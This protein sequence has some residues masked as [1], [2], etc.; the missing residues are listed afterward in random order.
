MAL[1]TKQQLIDRFESRIGKGGYYELSEKKAE[2]FIY[3][4]NREQQRPSA[5]FMT[6]D[7]FLSHSSSDAREVGGLK[8]KL[9]DL[10]YSVYV[11]WIEDPQLNRTKVTKANAETLRSRMK[12][13]KS[14][15]YAFSENARTSTWMPWELGFFDGI[16]GTVAVLP[17]V[18]GSPR[19]FK[20]NEYIELYPYIDITGSTL[21]VHESE[22]KYKKF[23]DWI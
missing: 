4:S 6:Y 14:F 8:L 2:E 9:E 19:S 10:G 21:Y 15:L 17:V 18:V 12:K 7:I 13:C 1:F 16:K 20:G 23:D 3:E 11:D 5:S 22:F